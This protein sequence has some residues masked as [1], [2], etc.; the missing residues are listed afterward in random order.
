MADGTGGVGGPTALC[1]NYYLLKYPQQVKQ[2][3]SD[4]AACCCC[5]RR[6]VL[7]SPGGR[8]LAALVAGGVGCLFLAH[9]SAFWLPSLV[10]APVLAGLVGS[11]D[12]KL[13]ALP[14]KEI[15]AVAVVLGGVFVLLQFVFVAPIRTPELFRSLRSSYIDLHSPLGSLRRL[16][17]TFGM[18]MA[19]GSEQLSFFTG[20]ALILIFGGC[21]VEA[22]RQ[23]MTGDVRDRSRVV[24]LVLGGALPFLCACVAGALQMYPVLGYPRTLMFS[25]PGI[26]LL[27][28]YAVDV[29]LGYL[30]LAHGQSKL[31]GGLAAAACVV[32]LAGSAFF[33]LAHPRAQ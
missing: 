31:I 18:M 32:L 20:I 17:T 4:F 10:L 33:Y 23:F 1:A 14:W 3:G 28:G 25:L 8:R 7:E 30:P 26:A 12:P 24:L 2:Y 19:P 15:I 13:G 11:R 5:W 6:G 21:S 22:W 29:M 27:L 9:T 16:I